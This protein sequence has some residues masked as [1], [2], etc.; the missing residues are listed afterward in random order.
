MWLSSDK[1][2]RIA[3]TLFYEET[4]GNRKYASTFQNTTID[5]YSNAENAP[6]DAETILAVLQGLFMTAVVLYLMYYACF[7]LDSNTQSKVVTSKDSTAYNS[8]WGKF[9]QQQKKHM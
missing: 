5:I 2:Y 1:K 3:H 4:N 8:N 6:A 9:P 7:S